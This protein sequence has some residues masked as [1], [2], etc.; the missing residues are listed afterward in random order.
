MGGCREGWG[1][2]PQSAGSQGH[3]VG[4]WGWE[5]QQ[6]ALLVCMHVRWGC[7]D[8]RGRGGV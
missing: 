4:L 7:G 3:R 1:S 5:G 8:V 2:C 6:E